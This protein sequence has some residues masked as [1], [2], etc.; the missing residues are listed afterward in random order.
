M[1]R[2]ACLSVKWGGGGGG[3]GWAHGARLHLN[4]YA[5]HGM[6]NVNISGSFSVMCT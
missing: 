3:G 6:C 1:R 5:A 2:E 4:Y